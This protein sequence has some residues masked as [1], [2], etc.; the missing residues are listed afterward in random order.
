MRRTIHCGIWGEREGLP[1]HCSAE[2]MML[3][4]RSLLTPPS[5]SSILRP[6][7]AFITS[8]RRKSAPQAKLALCSA[9]TCSSRFTKAL[10]RRS[11]MSAFRD[12]YSRLRN[13]LCLQDDDSLGSSSFLHRRR[14]KDN[15]LIHYL[16][17]SVLLRSFNF[18]DFFTSVLR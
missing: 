13:M 6:G 11:T 5:C 18:H 14:R 3:T 2:L 8:D 17:L 4:R 12:L 16:T 10:T 1:V 7:L 9:L 15:I